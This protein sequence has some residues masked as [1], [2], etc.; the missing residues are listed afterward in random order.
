MGEV[1]RA[2]LLAKARCAH[3]LEFMEQQRIVP[4]KVT[5]V[6]LK[7]AHPAKQQVGVDTWSG[8]SWAVIVNLKVFK[9]GILK[10]PSRRALT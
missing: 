7:H 9:N 3:A 8:R 4:L 1:L 10:W 6:D 5:W 2:L